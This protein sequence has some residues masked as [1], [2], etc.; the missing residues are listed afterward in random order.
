MKTKTHYRPRLLGWALLAILTAALTV[1]C[2]GKKDGASPAGPSV[3]EVN[4]DTVKSVLGTANDFASGV[5][6]VT[7]GNGEL[8]IAYRYYDADLGNY[9]ADFASEMAPRIQALYKKFKSLDRIHFQVT[10]NSAT[11]P[12]LWQPFAEFGVDRK[13]I[14]EIHWTGFLVKYLQDLVIKNK[15][16]S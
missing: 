8:I 4:L 2:Q 6:D 10:A 7:R 13:T 16:G 9:E 1:T 11:A 15:K 3:D 5:I 12:E 14:E